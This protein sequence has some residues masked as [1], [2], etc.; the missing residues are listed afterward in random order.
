[1]STTRFWG[2]PDD[3]VDIRHAED[4]SLYVTS[5]KILG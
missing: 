5:V 1:M 4:G 2:K 3:G